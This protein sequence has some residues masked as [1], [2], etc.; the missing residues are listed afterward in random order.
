MKKLH[1]DSNVMGCLVVYGFLLPGMVGKSCLF[2]TYRSLWT[3][4]MAAMGMLVSV[5]IF[6]LIFVLR[7]LSG[8]RRHPVTPNRYLQGIL[9]LMLTLAVASCCTQE[10][11]MMSLLFLAVHA[12]C[13]I[14]LFIYGAELTRAI[15]REDFL[16]LII[17][18]LAVLAVISVAARM[19]GLG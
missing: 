18:P 11:W 13:I 8:Q 12:G 19:A 6:H 9:L 16:D 17:I 1:F 5:A 15:V 3:I 7:A 14:V 4:Q 2:R 10:D